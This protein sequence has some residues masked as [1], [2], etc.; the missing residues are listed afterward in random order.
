MFS[1]NYLTNKKYNNS[2]WKCICFHAFLMGKSDRTIKKMNRYYWTTFL[3]SLLVTFSIF[4]QNKITFSDAA[5]RTGADK[6]WCGKDY[7]E[8]EWTRIQLNRDWDSQG[9]AKHDGFAFYRMRFVLPSAMLENSFWKDSLLF[10]MGKIDDAD[11]VYLNGKLIGKT[12]RFPD[13]PG[14]VQKAFEIERIYKIAVDNPALEWDKENVLAVKV[15]DIDGLGGMYEGFPY[16]QMV[17]LIDGLVMKT[18]F[19]KD[20][21]GKNICTISIANNYN[22]RLSGFLNIEII[23]TETDKKETYNKQKINLDPGKVIVKSIPFSTN[24]RYCIRTSY[25]EEKTKKIKSIDVIV[26]YILTP[27]EQETPK[28]NGARIFGVRP[29]SPFLFKIPASGEKPIKYA[30]ENLPEGL[31]VDTHSGIITG[32]LDKRGEYKMIFS[33]E[34]SKGKDKKPFTVKVGDLLALTPPMGWNSW[35]CWGLS[36]SDEKVRSSAQALISK[37][38]INYGWTYIN[39]DDAWENDKRE[40]NGMLLAN[41]KFPDMKAL[42]DWLH[43]MGLKFGIYS[44]PGPFTCGKYL[45]SY[46]H[47]KQDADMWASWGVDYL[48]YDWCD[49]TH[50][51]EQEGDHSLSAHM[52][53]Y[54][55]MEKALRNQSRDI[56]YS[57]CQYG[58]RDVWEWGA[59][60]DGNLWRTTGDIVDTWA[61]MKNIGFDRQAALSHFAK[62]GRWN[63]PDMLVVGK[64]GWSNKLRPT[65]L[66][67]DEQYTHITLWSLLA[68]PLLIG[69]DMDQLD[70]F[71]LNLLTNSEVIAINQDPLGRQAKRMLVDGDKQIWVKPLEDGSVAVGIFNLGSQDEVMDVKW[72]DINLPANRNVRDLWRQKDLGKFDEVFKTKVPSHGSVMIKVYE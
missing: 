56:V 46:Q 20:S 37:G 44:S 49:Y 52:K 61:S 18:D 72:S 26:P 12:G 38:L 31:T 1:E 66:T 6:L 28:I 4:S 45:G 39:V 3:F 65:R 59:A 35:N 63:D 53:P 70:D 25:I 23:D 22:I 33:V 36:V 67:Y 15:Y 41:N 48:K 71:T 57:L 62:P 2:H 16:I 24:K 19:E 30:V 47:E 54:Q 10:N 50:V 68:A 5:I 11:E 29:G 42:S 34:N 21:K 43:S 55:I 8:S 69:C 51:Y 32:I 9:F 60:V 58:M 27:K 13:D 14:A 7:D 17:D 64:V 40:Q